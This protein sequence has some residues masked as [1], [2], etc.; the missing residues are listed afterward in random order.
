M[1]GHKKR[2]QKN[3][4]ARDKR[5]MNG[6]EREF[7]LEGA[8]LKLVTRVYVI[9]KEKKSRGQQCADPGN[10]FRFMFC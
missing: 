1:C 3:L 4:E 10:H 8:E 9:M 2:P 6:E 5:E 7:F